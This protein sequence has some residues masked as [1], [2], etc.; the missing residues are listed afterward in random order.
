MRLNQVR[1]HKLAYAKGMSIPQIYHFGGIRSVIPTPVL[2]GIDFF[3]GNFAPEFGRATGGVILAPRARPGLGIG[4]AVD[5]VNLDAYL[6]AP[7]GGGQGSGTKS[8]KKCR[9]H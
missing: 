1:F 3:P 8:E 6:P 9:N 2:Q 4:L 5:T 7:A